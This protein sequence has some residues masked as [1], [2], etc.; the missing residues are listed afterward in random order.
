MTYR[1]NQARMRLLTTLEAI[2]RV[3]VQSQGTAHVEADPHYLRTAP[4]GPTVLPRP[5]PQSTLA[6]TTALWIMFVLLQPSRLRL[7]MRECRRRLVSE[8]DQ[9]PHP[10]RKSKRSSPAAKNPHAEGRI[11]KAT[12]VRTPLQPASSSGSAQHG[13][14]ESRGEAETPTANRLPPGTDGHGP[15]RHAQ[16]LWQED[17]LLRPLELCDPPSCHVAQSAPAKRGRAPAAG[18]ADAAPL[19]RRPQQSYTGRGIRRRL[20]SVWGV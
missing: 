3:D 8:S 15:M 7:W 11:G 6:N 1:R 14:P 17:P 12:G 19:A 2:Q 20:P 18:Q 5:Q 4:L 10:K 16:T 13:T 9:L